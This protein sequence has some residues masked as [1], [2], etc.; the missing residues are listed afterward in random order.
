LNQGS[1][2][3]NSQG[4]LSTIPAMEPYHEAQSGNSGYGYTGQM[5]GGS[6]EPGTI[7]SWINA[8][9][10]GGFSQGGILNGATLTNPGD[11]QFSQLIQGLANDKSLFAP[12]AAATPAPIMAPLPTATANNQAAYTDPSKAT[13][14]G[15]GAAPAPAPAPAPIPIPPA[16]LPAPPSPTLDAGSRN[17]PTLPAV[18][19]QGTDLPQAPS[20]DLSTLPGQSNMNQSTTGTPTPPLSAQLQNGMSQADI[21]KQGSMQPLQASTDTSTNMPKYNTVNQQVVNGQLQ[22]IDTQGSQPDQGGGMVSQD[23]QPDANQTGGGAM[24]N[25]ATPPPPVQSN[26]PP[27]Q[28]S[29]GGQIPAEHAHLGAAY[30]SYAPVN[31][32]Q[33][34]Q[35]AQQLEASD[36][37]NAGIDTSAQSGVYN[38]LNPATSST[39]PGSNGIL[40][41]ASD[42]DPD[43]G[44]EGTGT[45]PGGGM[46]GQAVGGAIASGIGAIGSAISKAY[47]PIKLPTIQ[48]VKMP[49]SPVFGIPKM[50]NQGN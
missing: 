12:A 38:A 30:Q 47:A 32:R 24:G 34:I 8:K 26:P 11:D 35:S 17:I 48:Q 20:T 13:I 31:A 27:I 5:V 9:G 43:P 49:D 18:S 44:L 22:S 41:T 37:S 33:P 2:F 21:I 7:R 10:Q 15:M 4:Q 29:N 25:P 1:S 46:N 28:S 6:P 50:S 39:T 40:N 16:P 36:P 14:P 19:R 3:Y 45:Q 42:P 23:A